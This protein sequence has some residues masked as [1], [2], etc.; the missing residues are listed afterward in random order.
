MKIAEEEAAAAEA[1]V[2][3]TAEQ[4]EL[5]LVESATTGGNIHS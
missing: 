2:A 4:N 5:A 3:A 1:V